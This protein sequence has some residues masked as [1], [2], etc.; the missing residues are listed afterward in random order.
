MTQGVRC[1]VIH[2]YLVKL[3][4][5]W[6]TTQEDL[7]NQSQRLHW[8]QHSEIAS[9]PGGQT[10]K[11][12]CMAGMPYSP[13][14]HICRN[15]LNMLESF[16]AVVMA[17]TSSNTGAKLTQ[18]VWSNHAPPWRRLQRLITQRHRKC[19]CRTKVAK[20]KPAK[21]LEAFGMS[22]RPECCQVL[23]DAQHL[24][25]CRPDSSLFYG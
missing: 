13:H 12:N 7:G 18:V 9:D 2:L 4:L 25:L 5:H 8:T 22:I 20:I 23:L 14:T 15:S 11:Q 17:R 24:H 6:T 21:D 19:W 16:W 3:R 10:R 1:V